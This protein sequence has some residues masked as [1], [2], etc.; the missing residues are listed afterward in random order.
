MDKHRKLSNRED[1]KNKNIE[2]IELKNIHFA[3]KNKIILKDISFKLTKGVVTGIY[4]PSGSG[5]TTL[6]DILSSLVI[7]DKGEILINNKLINSKDLFWGK[8]ISYIS[9][10]TDL[11]N[12]TIEYNISFGEKENIN[13]NKM[14]FS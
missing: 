9:Q 5:K 4:G 12:E 3:Y 8:E 14:N 6:L 1:F 10:S 13:K 7:P 11:F 2:T